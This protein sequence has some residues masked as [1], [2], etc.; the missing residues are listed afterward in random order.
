VRILHLSDCHLSRREGADAQGLDARATLSGLL[1]DCSGIDGLDLVVVSGDVADDGSQ[2]GY[3][4]ALGL[5]GEF[6]RDRGIGQAYCVGN[7]DDRDAFAS[8]LGS[9]HFDQAGQPA[10]TLACGPDGPR[11][12]VSEVSG[13]RVI[14][15][16]SLV[17]GQTHGLIS[18][19]QLAWLR[20]LLSRPASAGSVVILHHPPIAPA[21]EP[22]RSLNLRNAADLASPLEGSDVRAVLCGHFHAQFAGRLGDVP[23]WV[24]PGIFTRI[25]W[26]APSG[27]SRVV[28]GAAATVIDLDGPGS[29]MFY[30]LQARDPLAGQ[31]VCEVD[32]VAD[33]VASGAASAK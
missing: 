23:V 29:P 10:G 12:A 7:H 3:A 25:D 24:G 32:K 22:Q 2:E 33:T 11:A 18:P 19:D 14:T 26:S 16:D 15:L 6:A 1:R 8:V 17:P 13:Y 28:R 9:G 31:L 27:I 5:I 21:R 30:V 4:S 20:S